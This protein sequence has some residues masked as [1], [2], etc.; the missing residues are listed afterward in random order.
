MR[1]VL[2]LGALLVLVVG[3]FVLIRIGS[4]L[5]SIVARAIES[6]G[7]RAAGVPV[8]V[9]SVDLALTEG[10]GTIRGLRVG[11]PAG[12]AS[13]DAFRLGEITIQVDPK[14]ITGTPIAIP[15]IRVIAP[16]VNAEFD[17]KGKSNLQTILD[18]VKSQGAGGGESEA[19]PEAGEPIR[20]A[21]GRFVFEE[22]MLRG[23][24]SALTGDADDSFETTLPSLK[25]NNIGG[26]GGAT[27]SEISETILTAFLHQT[28]KSVVAYQAQ[29][30]VEKKLGG[31]LGKGVGK[32]LRGALE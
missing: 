22:G 24:A 13:G 29:R 12:Y 27:P 18:H 9:G 15:Q 28:T 16:E 21:V 2:L 31:D 26:S 23:D 8:R 11:N 17:A 4:N 20:L 19:T 7:T 25:L 5:E 1:R 32:L 10:K 30:A 14:S 3:A 6:Y